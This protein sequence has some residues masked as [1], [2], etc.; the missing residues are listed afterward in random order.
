MLLL[1]VASTAWI[2]LTG[3]P[4]GSQHPP[5]CPVIRYCSAVLPARK[6]A[7][8]APFLRDA[9]GFTHGSRGL[10]DASC[11]G[12]CGGMKPMKIG[13]AVLMFGLAGDRQS[14]FE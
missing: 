14:A 1:S 3:L 7:S 12:E 10:F 2:W 9:D 5:L 8:I 11:S 6:P 4:S 13:Q